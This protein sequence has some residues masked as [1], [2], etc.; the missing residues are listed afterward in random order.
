MTTSCE[1]LFTATSNHASKG[2]FSGFFTV[3]RH[4]NVQRGGYWLTEVLKYSITSD[5]CRTSVVQMPRQVAHRRYC[6]TM[7][8]PT[9]EKRE[10]WSEY[11]KD[12]N[13]RQV[14]DSTM[15]FFSAR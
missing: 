2:I 3:G 13:S 10:S 6:G 5:F 14:N 15:K 7:F 8:F 11:M 9:L 1:F 12:L 4:P